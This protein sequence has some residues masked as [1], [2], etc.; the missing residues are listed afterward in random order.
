MCLQPLDIGA[1]VLV[2]LLR[3]MRCDAAWPGRIC[4]FGAYICQQPTHLHPR[5]LDKLFEMLQR[6]RAGV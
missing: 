6:T 4:I 3:M 2:R 1:G 5:L